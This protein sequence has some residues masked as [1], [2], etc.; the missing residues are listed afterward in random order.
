MSC[1]DT[2]G[3]PTVMTSVASEADC[4]LAG[5]VFVESRAKRSCAVDKNLRTKRDAVTS[6]ERSDGDVTS[7][8]VRITCADCLWAWLRLEPMGALFDS[9]IFGS[10]RS[11]AC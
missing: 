1:L 2:G 7:A 5:A 3:V 11:S 4:I 6:A 10:C 8:G 9:D